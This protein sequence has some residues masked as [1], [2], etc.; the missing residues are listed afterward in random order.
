MVVVLSSRLRFGLCYALRHVL[1]SVT[2]ALM[3]ALGVFG[4]LYP[5]PYYAMLGVADI[6]VL[7][8]AAD[9][10]CGPLL[11][12][13]LASPSK[14]RR[15]R[16]V[17][18]SLVG[19]VQ[20]AALVYGLHSLWVARPV[21]LAFEVDR[22]VVVTA[23]EVDVSALAYAPQGMRHLPTFGVMRVGTR[24]AANATEMMESVDLGL[25]G[26]SSAMRPGWWTPWDDQRSAMKARAKPLS[27]LTARRPQ[28]AQALRDAA[29]ATG[30]DPAA[31]FYLPLTSRKVKEWVALLDTGMNV[32]GYAPVDG[33]D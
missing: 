9:V 31:L 4:L 33:F 8:L 20:L 10:V 1:I 22:L 25:S 26:I 30:A 5:V 11:T 19:L 18:F 16:W 3:S 14:S 21:V 17:D 24:R 23:N 2:V 12:L 28:D 15:E 27:E 7:L 32:V 13:V 29:K 6:Y